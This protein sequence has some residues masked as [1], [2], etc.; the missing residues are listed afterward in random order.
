M[1]KCDHLHTFYGAAHALF[2]VSLAVEDG[3]VVCILGRNGAGKSTTLRSIMG[4]TPPRAGTVNFDGHRIDGLPPY[5]IAR[6]G[7]GYVPEDRRVFA[8]LSVEDNLLV[9]E[10]A[11]PGGFGWTVAKAFETF[12]HLSEFRNR[13][14]GYLSGGQQ[15][16]LTIARTLMSNPSVL[17]V[18]EP[19]E[20]LAPVMVKTL[21]EAILA[22][23]RQG[24][25][26]LVAAQDIRF[27]AAIADY[28]YVMKR[29]TIVYEG[30]RIDMERDIDVVQS[31]F[32][33]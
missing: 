14:A 9:A 25:T 22:L 33:V 15:Q 19:T 17:L 1:L 24:L 13:A 11:R 28:L 3:T 10:R 8:D 32:V 18:D 21:E 27:A 30:R 16:M 5:K 23:K 2:D 6:L 20:G 7:L 12:P 4:L 26:M 31:H 29:G